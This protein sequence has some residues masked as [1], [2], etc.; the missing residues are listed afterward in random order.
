MGKK[1]RIKSFISNIPI[2]VVLLALFIALIVMFNIH[3]Y[4]GGSDLPAQIHSAIHPT[5]RAYTITKPIFA[6]LYYLFNSYIGIAMFLALMVVSTIIATYF[7]FKH[8]L[9]NHNKYVLWAFSIIC[10]F[11]IAIYLP[12]LNPSM[13]FGLQEGTEWHNA[14]YICMK[15]FGLLSILL[16]LKIK[17][18]YLQH[19]DIKQWILFSLLLIITAA[20]KPILFLFLLLQCSYC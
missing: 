12:F 13:N 8:L 16:Y 14:T 15:L 5:E 18:S 20:F 6:G 19:I 11:V 1:S 10:N 9:P 2:F 7:L 4:G 17:E 3:A